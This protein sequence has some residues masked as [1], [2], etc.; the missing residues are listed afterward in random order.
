MKPKL[1][2][3]QRLNIW[4]ATVALFIAASAA[5]AQEPQVNFEKKADLPY[6][7]TYA[8][9]CNDGKYL[10]AANGLANG[11]VYSTKLLRYDPDE[12]KWEVLTDKLNAKINGVAAYVPSMHKIYI[13]GG[14]LADRRGFYYNIESVDTETGAVTTLKVSNP[15]G[16]VN[17]GV[18]VWNNK[19]YIFGGFSEAGYPTRKIY[20]FDPATEKF[21]KL[22]Y[23]P[24]T[25]NVKGAIVDGTLYTFGGR[26]VTSNSTLKQVYAYNLIT[27]TYTLVAQMP[28]EIR[29]PAVSQRANYIFLTS[30]LNHNT[31]L[32]YFNT[33][34][35]TFTQ[36]QSNM[37]GR[38]FTNT[39]IIGNL[40]YVYGGGL[41]T[42]F[43]GMTSTQ[44]T[45][46]NQ[47]VQ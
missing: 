41:S 16:A 6:R 17:S 20:E 46:V 21:T 3:Y 10:Y 9:Y 36:L 12:D 14:I 47:M 28:Q 19:V 7:L 43:P 5:Y 2:F 29:E 39:G 1:R 44:A 22:K 18:A 45:D 13:M 4:F 23:L 35:A 31:F 26:D 37:L 11:T 8:A 27:Q 33:Q 30:D 40:F 42:S 24:V 32:G 34:T 25:G 15:A 38:Q